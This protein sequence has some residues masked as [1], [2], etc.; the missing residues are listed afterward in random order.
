MDSPDASS[1]HAADPDQVKNLMRL[2]HVLDQHAIVSVTDAAGRITDANALF[3]AISGYSRDELLGCNHRMLKSGRHDAAFYR[4][5]WETIA[6]GETWQGEI[7]NRRK[8]G[9]EYWVRST[10]VP[11][12]D[13]A[14][15]PEQY[16]SIRTDITAVKAQQQA[17]L[18]SEER[19][20]RGQAAANI[21]TWDW[22]MLTGELF[23]SERVAPLFGLPADI[24]E[25]TYERFLATLHPEDRDRVTA[26]VKASVEDG[27]PYEVEHRVVWP[28]G[29]VRW[30]LERG[31]VTRDGD[32]QAMH[33][34]GVVK[35]I[36]ERK[37]VELDL[38]ESEKRLRE[39]EARFSFA[40]EGAGDGVWDLDVASGRMTLSGHYESMLGYEPGEIEP[41]VAAWSE[42][43]HPDDMPL[44][45]AHMRAYLE[46]RLPVLAMEQRM[47]CK[48]GSYKW[49]LCRGTAVERDADGRA[50]RL[51]GIHSD[52]SAIK[53]AAEYLALFRRVFDASTQC[54]GIAD[55]QGRLLYQNRAHA[56]LLGY[57]DD[58]IEGM[59]FIRLLPAEDAEALAAKILHMI[60][61]DQVLIGQLPVRRKDGSVFTSFSN[62]GF[63]KD[64][65]GQTQYIFNIF[66][67]FSEELA[68]RNELAEAKEA[69]ERANQ[70][71][72]DFL[73]SMSHELRTPMNAILG[74]A[75]LLECDDE[76]TADQRD[77]ANEILKAGRHLLTLINEVLDL[78]RI[79]AGRI[80]L[81]LEP[82]LLREAVEDCRQLVQPLA[83]ARGLALEVELPEAAVVRA[84]RTRLKQ[85]LLNL[86]SNAVKYNR[87]G[88]SVR[89]S[90][91]PAGDML[92]VAVA[93][94]GTGIRAERLG[95]LFEPFNRLGAEQSAVEGTGIGLSITRRLME[96]MGGRIGAESEPGVGSTFWI[97][98]VADTG[99]PVGGPAVPD[100]L[101]AALAA[102]EHAAR[103][104]CIDD[105]PV[106]LKLVAQL[107]ARRPRLRL[108]SAHTP[109]LGI[110]LARAHRPE[111]ILLDINMP[112]MDGYAVLRLLKEDPRLSAIPVIAV[113]AN[114]LPRDIERGRAA[115][116]ADYLIKPL[117]LDGFLAAI[118]ACL[119]TGAA[120]SAH[121][122]PDSSTGDH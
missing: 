72:S 36:H 20:R 88:G 30:L 5:I 119:Q 76:L 42:Q 22:N 41:T 64:G 78:A 86:L 59:H 51:I 12:L 110:E 66:T 118:D 83:A 14:G 8:D 53:A 4:D 35:D 108:S 27:R 69:A 111:L 73:S 9:S 2:A 116:F 65:R 74:F 75:Q 55:G 70:A 62:L 106:N 94:T 63:V 45:N 13:A 33:M 112:G 100:A 60:A 101:R 48:D 19:L 11:F 87:D 61:E 18:V 98:L 90:A 109:Q 24:R 10:I 85:V 96:L 46:G 104:L 97:E 16:I 56:R 28:D 34:L 38:A 32:G 122:D 120:V 3:C 43:V 39:T 50:R 58:E 15:R 79:E 103:I 81:S 37:L 47:R 57:S 95:E 114:A 17:L 89:L 117:M 113:T 77:N 105:N 91:S 7:C 107:L 29:T 31:A 26:G 1:R 44:I 99:R 93:D 23:W 68:R 82:V 84:D 115:G 52:I 102:A 80:D 121:P 49:V 40:V 67:D 54:V 21:G 71:K 92:R 25:T 6:G